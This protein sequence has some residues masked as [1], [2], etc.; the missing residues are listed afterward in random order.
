MEEKLGGL[1]LVEKILSHEATQ[2]VFFHLVE[3]LLVLQ[4]KNTKKTNGMSVDVERINKM[5][6]SYQMDVYKKNLVL[7][8]MVD[9]VLD[10]A[11]EV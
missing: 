8:V 5:K 2:N 3:V 4:K 7:L 11:C 10:G 6:R 9:G 1:P